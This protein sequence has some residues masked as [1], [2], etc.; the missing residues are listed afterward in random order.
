MGE[1]LIKSKKTIIFEV[2]SVFS[3]SLLFSDIAI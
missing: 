3:K 1:L 2:L